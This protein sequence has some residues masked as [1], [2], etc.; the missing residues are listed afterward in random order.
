MAE[1]YERL[2]GCRLTEEEW[3]RLWNV[4]RKTEGTEKEAQTRSTVRREI[5]QLHTDRYPGDDHCMICGKS[6]TGKRRSGLCRAC[7][8]T[9]QRSGKLRAKWHVFGEGY[10]RTE[11]NCLACGNPKVFARHM[12]ENCYT[13]G[14]RRNLATWQQVRRYKLQMHSRVAPVMNITPEEAEEYGY[15][16]FTPSTPTEN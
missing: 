7:M 12:C 2:E 9:L 15:D 1:R 10:G 3:E 16:S 6:G 13:I 11:T 14:R 8:T 4:L 5:Q